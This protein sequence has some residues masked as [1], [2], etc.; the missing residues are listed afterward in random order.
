MK[1]C[2]ELYKEKTGVDVVVTAGPV[3]QWI[4]SAQNDADLVYGGA[5]YMLAQFALDYPGFLVTDSS[6]ELYDRAIGI[7]VRPGNPKHLQSIKDLAK[8]SVK[9]L[10]VNGAGQVGAWEDLAGK[11]H[12]ITA[13]SANITISVQNTALGVKAWNAQPDLDAWITF[14]SWAK[15]M[16]GKVQLVRLPK[17]ERL[18]RGTPIGVAARSIQLAKAHAFINFLKTPAAHAVFIKWG[19]R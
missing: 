19:W 13:L 14:E 16:P 6:V 7:L 4:Q 10:D 12:L 1:E 2:A 3:E 18:Y 8:P 11:D 17:A 9:L 5:D 15:R